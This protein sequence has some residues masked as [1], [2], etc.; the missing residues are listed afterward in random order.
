MKNHIRHSLI[1]LLIFSIFSS[2]SIAADSILPK[3]K[4]IVDKE[5]KDK[6]SKDKNCGYCEPIIFSKKKSKP[7]DTVLKK[8][9]IINSGA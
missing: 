7:D 3:P 9:A 4:P 2:H 1:I 5:I 6:I 8:Q